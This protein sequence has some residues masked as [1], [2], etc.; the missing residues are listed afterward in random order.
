VGKI[1]YNLSSGLKRKTIRQ[2]DGHAGNYGL[3]STTAS[4]S[5]K[6]KELTHLH[7][8]R[9]HVMRVRYERRLYK[10]R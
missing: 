1:V 2:Q 10:K 6:T 9:Q 4:D 8:D 3:T 7:I 5:R